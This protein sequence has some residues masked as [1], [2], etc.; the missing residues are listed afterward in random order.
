MVD[1][2]MFCVRIEVPEELTDG[3]F[4]DGGTI[5]YYNTEKMCW[6]SDWDIQHINSSPCSSASFV[7][8]KVTRLVAPNGVDLNL[9]NCSNVS[10]LLSDKIRCFTLLNG[11]IDHGGCIFQKAFLNQ[12]NPKNQLNLPKK[13]QN[14]LQKRPKNTQPQKH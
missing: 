13:H 11:V 9:W 7:N 14:S 3:I 1:S 8:N 4:E 6:M 10:Y 2:E 5:E 12:I